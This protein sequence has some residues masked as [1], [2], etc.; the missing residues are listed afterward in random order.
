[1]AFP[2]YMSRYI[3]KGILSDF[4]NVWLNSYVK[5]AQ[6]LLFTC[7]AD[8]IIRNM[9]LVF[10]ANCSSAADSLDIYGKLHGCIWRDF[11]IGKGYEARYKTGTSCY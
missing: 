11:A 8:F 7:D 6:K 2:L 9:S 1:M 3:C 5:R 4:C 10:V